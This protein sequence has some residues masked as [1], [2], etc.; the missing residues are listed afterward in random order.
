M[1]HIN[2]KI[3]Y[4]R[5]QQR[6]DRMPIGAPEHRALFELLAE[7]FSPEEAR[8]AAAVPLGLVSARKIAKN[9]DMDESRAK[10]IIDALVA[11]GLLADLP[12]S[13]GRVSYFLNPTMVG[14]FEFTM[15]RVRKDIDQ[16]RVGKLFHEYLH[17]PA[18][19]L[20]KLAAKG[21]TFIARPLVHEDVLKQGTY[22]EVLDYEKASRIIGDAGAWAEA[23]CYCRH[24]KEHV[25]ERCE[26]PEDFCLSFGHGADY[27]T[28]NGFAKP[29]TRDRALGVLKDA[30]ELGL[31]QMCDNVKREPGFICNCC[32]CCCE[33]LGSLRAFP[34]PT[35]VV[36]SNYVSAIDDAECNGCG[37][38][39]KACPIDAISVS[40]AGPTAKYP[41][42]KKTATVDADRCIGCG[43]CNRSC[44]YTAMDMKP[45]GTRVHTPE[46]MMEKM[47]LQ[48]LEQGKLQNFIFSDP[49]KLTHRALASLVVTIANLPPSK[50][51]LAQQQLKSKFVEMMLTLVPRDAKTVS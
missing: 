18:K 33:M 48:A 20:F 11:K 49:T 36:T 17:D 13:D 19:G 38:C 7:L 37:K 31:V 4:R 51:L 25:G 1:G 24:V 6:L 47:L 2:A 21:E 14:F 46:D 27:L 15:M 35:P 5:L 26:Y 39:A 30:R 50:R 9:A 28:R 16:H 29:I 42:R 45:I 8:V 12:R 23:M 44:K 34:G 3:E 40:P 10:P 41:K 22:T 32:G 43:V